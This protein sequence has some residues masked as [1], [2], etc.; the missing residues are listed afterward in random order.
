MYAT[1]IFPVLDKGKKD[2]D[3]WLEMREK[4]VSMGT[5]IYNRIDGS[6]L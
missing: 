3:A 5:D 2:Q 4:L 6:A 1:L